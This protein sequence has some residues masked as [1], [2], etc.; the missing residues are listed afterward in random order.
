MSIGICTLA[1]CYSDLVL[2]YITTYKHALILAVIYKSNHYKLLPTR[3]AINII[4]I[5]LFLTLFWP[6]RQSIFH[7]AII[8]SE[9]ELCTLGKMIDYTD[10]P[11]KITIG[12]LA[13]ITFEIVN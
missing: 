2:Y 8:H 12:F 13:P 11:P 6:I 5:K 4:H 7:K 10:C 3:M 1:D 9:I